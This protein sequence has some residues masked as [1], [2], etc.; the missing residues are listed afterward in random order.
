MDKKNKIFFIVF[1]LLII[2]SVGATYYRTMIKKDYMISAQIDCDPY[3]EKCFI[4]ECDPTSTVEGEACTGELEN[5]I[6]Y[7][8]IVERRA[9]NIPSCDP[10]DENCEALV[11]PDGEEDC[12]V[13]FCN[14]EN[15]VEQGVECS[16]PVQYAIDNP[17]E[18]EAEECEEGDEEC[19]ASEEEASECE[20]GDEE[21]LAAEEEDGEEDAA[22]EETEAADEEGETETEGE[23]PAVNSV[24]PVDKN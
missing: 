17:E 13:I 19:L 15:K 16:D 21:C 6:W 20:E 7:Y 2:G 10:N 14:E 5:D 18:E 8:Q 3:T 23:A 12:D 22:A 11:C 24:F 4:W 1:L 9:Y